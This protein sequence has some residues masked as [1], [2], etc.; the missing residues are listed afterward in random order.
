[1]STR[2]NI[3]HIARAPLFSLLWEPICAGCSTLNHITAEQLYIS[4]SRLGSDRPFKNIDETS[5]YVL[6]L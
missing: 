1:M 6:S 3:R 4:L 5:Q 2:E